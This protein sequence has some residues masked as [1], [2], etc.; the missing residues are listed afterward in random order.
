M[1]KEKRQYALF[2]RQD[3]K[4]VRISTYSYKKSAAVRLFQDALLAPLLGGDC[5]GI[6]ELRPV[7]E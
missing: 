1:A 7:R 5:K 6:R 4:W 2:E 3:G